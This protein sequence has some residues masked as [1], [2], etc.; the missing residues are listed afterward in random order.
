MLE[1]I[2][3][4]PDYFDADFRMFYEDLDLAWR[5]NLFGWKAYYIPSAVAYHVRGGTARRRIGINKPFARKYLDEELFS[6]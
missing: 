1:E 2:K 5:A 3:L 6:I 4:G